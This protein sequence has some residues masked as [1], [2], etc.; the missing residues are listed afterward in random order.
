MT[1]LERARKGHCQS[2]GN[3]NCFKS[4]VVET[5]ESERQGRAHTGFSKCTN[6]TLN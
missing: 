4:N 1:F 6:T 2:D 5:C 3:W